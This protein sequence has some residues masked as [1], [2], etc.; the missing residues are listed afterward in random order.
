MDRRSFKD[1]P[2][3]QVF[4][5]VVE[6]RNIEL[7]VMYIMT[8]TIQNISC[9]ALR[10]RLSPPLS[11]CFKI[12]DSPTRIIAPGMS[13]KVEVKFVAKSLEADQTD[14]LILT[15]NGTKIDIPL[16]AYVPSSQI[17]FNG[18]ADLGPV[19]LENRSATFIDLVNTGK[20]GKAS[21]TW[22]IRTH[23]LYS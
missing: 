1:G 21:M 16:R 4:P 7:D 13:V 10:Y 2:S 23:I 11:K 6:F 12:V 17:E 3:L 22:N 15:S 5:A 14:N 20:P 9:N 18:F 19:V 8:L